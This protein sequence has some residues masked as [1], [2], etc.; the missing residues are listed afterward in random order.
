MHIREAAV[1]AVVT[2][3]ELLVI[4]SEQVHHRGMN[5]V[6]GRRIGTI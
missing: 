6:A 2:D 1:E 5:V 3:G 4:N